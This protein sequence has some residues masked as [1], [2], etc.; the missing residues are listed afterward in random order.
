MST[1]PIHEIKAHAPVFSAGDMNWYAVYTCVNQ[2]RVVAKRMD[3]KGIENFLPLYKSVRKRSDRRVVLDLPLFPG[4]L[5]VRI[6]LASRL[7]VLEIPRVVRIVSHNSAPAPLP[8]SEIESLRLGLSHDVNAEPCDYLRKGCRVR[9]IRGPFAGSEGILVR[10]KH[11][12][13]VVISI[14]MIRQSFTFEVGEE[15]L[16]RIL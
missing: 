11:G 8:A 10:R 9:V 16:E 13:R 5:F 3:E 1:Q 6:P 15:D 2:E 14:E 7:R 12:Y 4:Y